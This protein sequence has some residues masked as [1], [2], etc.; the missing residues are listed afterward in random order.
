MAGDLLQVPAQLRL[1]ACGRRSCDQGRTSESSEQGTGNEEPLGKVHCPVSSRFLHR[2][3]QNS[4]I[5]IVKI[6]ALRNVRRD[7]QSETTVSFSAGINAYL[8]LWRGIDART[9]CA[10]VPGATSPTTLPNPPHQSRPPGRHPISRCRSSPN[11][12]LP[13]AVLPLYER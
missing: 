3:I 1:H 12:E 10:R 11:R 13:S 6:N 8:V 5:P 7:V 2:C 9:S 4:V